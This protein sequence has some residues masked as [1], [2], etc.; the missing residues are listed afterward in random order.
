MRGLDGQHLREAFPVVRAT[1]RRDEARGG[2]GVT[3]RELQRRRPRGD[4]A[5]EVAA[6]VL[7]LRALEQRVDPAGHR[8][9]LRGLEQR[10]FC[11]LRVA[12][13]A[14]NLREAEPRLGALGRGQRQLHQRL[15][16]LDGARRVVGQR[17]VAGDGDEP[18]GG[19]GDDGDV[20]ARVLQHLTQRR[21]LCGFVARLARELGERAQ[22][23]HRRRRQA[24]G[25]REVAAGRDEV[26]RHAVQL[27]APRQQLGARFARRRGDEPRQQVEALALMHVVVGQERQQP[28]RRPLVVRLVGQHGAQ[29]FERRRRAT[30]RQRAFCELTAQLVTRL[31]G[32]A[33]PE[34]AEQIDQRL[35]RARAAVQ[36]RQ[37]ELRVEVVGLERGEAREQAARGVVVAGLLR[38][39]RGAAR[40]A[41]EVQLQ[42]RLVLR[43]GAGAQHRFEVGQRLARVRRLDELRATEARGDEARVLLEREREEGL[44]TRRLAGQR[45]SAEVPA[46]GLAVVGG[47]RGAATVEARGLLRS[48][49]VQLELRHR[50]EHFARAS[51]GRRGVEGSGEPQHRALRVA[52]LEECLRGLEEERRGVLRAAGLQQRLRARGPEVGELAGRAFFRV[53]RL[54]AAS[55]LVVEATER[56][57]ERV[58]LARGVLV[59]QL[60]ART[61]EARA[62]FSQLLGR[63]VA[64]QQREDIFERA[65]RVER[66]L[67]AQRQRRQ[68]EQP[69]DLGEEARGL[70][71][72]DERLARAAEAL[73]QHLRELAQRGG[74]EALVARVL[75]DTRALLERPREAGHVRA[76]TL[77][78]RELAQHWQVVGLDAQHFARG[79]DCGVEIEREVARRH[80][81]AAVVPHAV[82]RVFRELRKR[83]EAAAQ[84][85]AV[86]LAL[87]ERQH[88]FQREAVLRVGLERLAQQPFGAVGLVETAA[89]QLTRFSPQRGAARG[90][91][92]DGG[93]LLAGVGQ[94]GGLARRAEVREQLVERELVLRVE[95]QGSF[96]VFARARRL[97]Q[98]RLEQPRQR[99]VRGVRGLAD[100]FGA[101]RRARKLDRLLVAGDGFL[102]LAERFS[103]ARRQV[104]RL[105]LAGQQR[106]RFVEAQERVL[107]LFQAR[108][109]HETGEH[110]GAADAVHL[111]AT[112]RDFAHAIE[113]LDGSQPLT[114]PV[115]ELA[116][117][118][119]RLGVVR[120]QT[121]RRFT[122]QARTSE[123]VFGLRAQPRE[124]HVRVGGIGCVTRQRREAAVRTN[125]ARAVFCLV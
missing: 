99:V 85:T 11:A 42:A 6:R 89:V 121:Q 8:A 108:F 61:A 3:R 100:L 9:L 125:G 92:D 37:L 56:E 87:G 80:D 5:V 111:V 21:Q 115:A 123:I 64:R 38:G 84:L 46:R 67:E 55:E 86:A 36:L 60:L 76:A 10:L 32:E 22:Q 12:G 77:E 28:R 35:Q 2:H 1:Q 97:A 82:L 90:L 34:L 48:A 57:R 58:V 122:V 45:S 112:H 81:E 20:G 52:V 13:L 63:R 59:A 15:E 17:A 71:Q 116:Q 41:R 68:L 27:G 72:R 54:E 104:V 118:E 69:V 23:R 51:A 110:V 74:G 53:E 73:V 25:F 30:E 43:F 124:L 40:E 113:R 75:G 14:R 103:D 33:W 62:H 49:A 47:E 106:R 102:Q 4:G 16:G 78:G 120:R 24:R 31:A 39:L 19:L 91:V 44:F 50:L 70:F 26:A 95:R 94:L 98:L 96:E 107:G 65:A 93:G 109:P 83:R 101:R 105:R 7:Q 88:A 117:L 114:R 119:E 29:R 18:L 79:V 66:S